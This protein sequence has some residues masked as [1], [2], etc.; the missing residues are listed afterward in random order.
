MT[1]NPVTSEI[2]LLF[3]IISHLCIGIVSSN[4][5]DFKAKVTYPHL[6]FS[7]PVS[8]LEPLLHSFAETGDSSV[9]LTLDQAE[10][11]VS[12]V[13]RLQVSQSKL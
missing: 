13:W 11:D 5:R 12:R 3:V 10:E 2:N 9:F 7:I 6:N 4:T 1:V 8:V